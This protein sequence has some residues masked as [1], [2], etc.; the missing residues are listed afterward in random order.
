MKKRKEQETKADI[1]T[2]SPVLVICGWCNDTIERRITDEDLW[3]VFPRLDSLRNQ[4]L[5]DWD[6]AYSKFASLFGGEH[7]P[8]CQAAAQLIVSKQQ[9]SPQLVSRIRSPTTTI[10][11]TATPDDISSRFRLS[12][13]PEEDT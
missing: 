13:N 2:E 6:C 5:H 8:A 3:S 9:R 12:H 11:V 7:H 4:N 10:V 1:V